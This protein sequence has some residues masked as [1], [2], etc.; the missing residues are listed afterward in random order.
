MDEIGHF[1]PS[2]NVL[3]CD[4]V[5]ITTGTAKGEVLKIETVNLNLKSYGIMVDDG[6]FRVKASASYNENVLSRSQF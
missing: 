6:Q 4:G 1:P 3:P 2:S 5:N